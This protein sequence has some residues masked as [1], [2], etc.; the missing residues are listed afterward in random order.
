MITLFVSAQL[1]HASRP[2]REVLQVTWDT[3]TDCFVL[4]L[5]SLTRKISRNLAKNELK[6]ANVTISIEIVSIVMRAEDDHFADICHALA[7]KQTRKPFLVIKYYVDQSLPMTHSLNKKRST[8]P[9]PSL[10]SNC[11]LVPL[12]VNLTKIFGSFILDPEYLD[13]SDCSG[14][15]NI[16]HNEEQFTMH[17]R[18]IQRFKTSDTDG[19][20]AKRDIC[21]VP[22]SYKT[23]EVLLKIE[24]GGLGIVR[25]ED[26]IVT[27]CSCR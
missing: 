14:S 18:I 24:N 11:S 5:T 4:N 15:C 12:V 13:I 1:E 17:A 9:T 6:Q 22:S 7:E 21:C 3:Q 27:G 19:G 25:F 23:K 2:R 20:N 10:S 8:A 26:M 16:M